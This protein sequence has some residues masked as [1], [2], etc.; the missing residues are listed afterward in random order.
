MQSLNKLRTC[1]FRVTENEVGS[2]IRGKMSTLGSG[3]HLA[4]KRYNKG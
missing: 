3:K 4:Y 1:V 2:G